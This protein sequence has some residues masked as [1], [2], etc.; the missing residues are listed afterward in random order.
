MVSPRCTLGTLY[1]QRPSATRSKLISEI[2]EMFSVQSIFS[3]PS[4][5]SADKPQSTKMEHPRGVACVRRGWFCARPPSSHGSILKKTFLLTRLPCWRLV[6]WPSG[7]QVPVETAAGA[8]SLPA[9]M[10][11]RVKTLPIRISNRFSRPYSQRCNRERARLSRDVAGIYTCNC[12]GRRPEQWHIVLLSARKRP[13]R[14]R[15]CEISTRRK[16]RRPCQG[17]SCSPLVLRWNDPLSQ[18]LPA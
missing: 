17:P 3:N 11:R 1:C 14:R 9:C 16:D 8:V 13:A 5:P 4:P 6:C 12:F 10:T 18:R 15:H 2:I 7:E